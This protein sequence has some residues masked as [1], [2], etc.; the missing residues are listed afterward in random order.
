MTWGTG[1]EPKSKGEGKEDIQEKDR[2]EEGARFG[3]PVMNQNG[4]RIETGDR[5]G[6]DRNE[7]DSEKRSVK[8]KTKKINQ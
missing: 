1:D 4:K 3:E 2:D 8:N 6:K 5:Q 7:E